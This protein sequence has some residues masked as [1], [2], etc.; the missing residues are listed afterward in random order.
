[1][2]NLEDQCKTCKLWQKPIGPR[3]GCDIHK[4][5][6]TDRNEVAWK[7]LHLFLDVNG[8]CKNWKSCD[9][10]TLKISYDDN[11]MSWGCE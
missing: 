2:G 8:K 4:K 6:I 5:L 10:N 9:S 7:H 11:Q 1:M 3:S